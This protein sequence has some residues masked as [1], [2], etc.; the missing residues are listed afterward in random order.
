MEI[1]FTLYHLIP[2][3]PMIYVISPKSRYQ[4]SRGL[5]AE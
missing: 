1:S 3:N 2:C 5:T 4:S